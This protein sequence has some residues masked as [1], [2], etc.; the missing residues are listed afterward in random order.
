MG[1]NATSKSSGKRIALL[2]IMTLLF[3][4][5]GIYVGIQLFSILH[6]TYKT[7]TAIAATM[8]D[9]VYLNGV[10][11]FEA[12]DVTGGEGELGY[13]VEDGERVTG[14]TAL[15]E[16][17]TSEEQ[18]VLRER[19]DRLDR[20]ID[21]LTKSENS[22]GSDLTV[23]TT[24]T[25]QSLY[26][27]LD[28]LE[29]ASYSDLSDA[30]DA[31]LLA[32]N[33]LQISTGQVDGFA[34]T[35]ATLQAERE[36]VEAQLGALETITAQTNGYFISASLTPFLQ[37]DAQT[38]SDAS[39]VDL[40][41]MLEGGIPQ[42]DASLVGRIITGFSWKFYAVCDLDTAARF[43]GLKTVKISVPGKENSPLSATVSEVTVDEENGVAKVVLECQSINAD[44][45][46]LGVE[47]AQI[48]LKTY[49][50]IR[51]DRSALH[52][53]NG[54]YGVYVKY[55]NI[56]RFRKIEILYENG[57]YILVPDDGALG[58]DNE[59]RLYDEVIVEGSNLQDGKL[60]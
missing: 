58:T 3:L 5:A 22:A 38:L 35:I 54:E 34:N 14:G 18:G 36:S 53:V 43:D 31:F 21:L 19:L 27:L 20:V 28:I 60:L 56:Q 4:T 25:R 42:A 23:L 32:Q 51:V 11:V 9:S 24:E 13:L 7:E 12:V 44:V 1:N 55:G 30:E 8:A 16:V 41:Q 48:D 57:N 46:R 45:L 37:T 59:L 17:Y 50:G 6:R 15:A 49:T 47:E 33:R 2:V 26:D 29:N 39:P 40:Q 52:I 10:A